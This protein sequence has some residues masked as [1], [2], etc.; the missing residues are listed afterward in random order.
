MRLENI[1]GNAP[2]GVIAV[3]VGVPT[4]PGAAPIEPRPAGSAVLFGLG[5]ASRQDEAHAGNGLTVSI[6]ITDAVRELARELQKMPAQLEIRLEQ[7]S[8]DLY[9]A[10][11]VA[12]VSII[13]AAKA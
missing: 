3:H 13:R 7:P 2:S 6:E 4:V 9:G 11:D 1:S 12:K 5:K 8:G 10:V